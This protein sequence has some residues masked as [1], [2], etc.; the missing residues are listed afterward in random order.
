[1]STKLPLSN[2]EAVS[3]YLLDQENIKTLSACEVKT[4][5]IFQ[6]EYPKSDGVYDARMGTL[7]YAWKCGTCMQSKPE[8]P[9][10][11]GSIELNYPVIHPFYTKYIAKLLKAVCHKCGSIIN[12]NGKKSLDFYAKQNASTKE[13]SHQCSCKNFNPVIEFDKTKLYFKKTV[14]VKKINKTDDARPDTQIMHNFET[15]NILSRITKESYRLMGLD[16]IDPSSLILR[17]LIIPANSIRPELRKIKS[18]RVN[19]N[20]INVNL[21][22][23]VQ[24][25]NSISATDGNPSNVQLEIGVKLSNVITE[26]IK[27]ST[28]TGFEG[29]GGAK[30]NSISGAW[31]SKTGRIRR[32]ILG[33]R[34]NNTARGFITCDPD[35]EIDEIGIPLLVAK[36]NEAYE[37]VTPQNIDRL[38]TYLNNGKKIYPGVLKIIKYTETGSYEV[39]IGENTQIKEGDTVVRN[40]ITG[41][42]VNFNRQPSL[43]PSSVSSMRIKV[44]PDS[45]NFSNTKSFRMNV[46]SCN[47]FGADFDG[48]AMTIICPRSTQSSHEISVLSNPGENFVTYKNAKPKLG[49]VLDS[50]IGIAE[51]TRSKTNYSKFH[52]MQ[53]FSKTK[54]YPIFDKEKYSGRELVSFLLTNNRYHINY[55]GKPQFYDTTTAINCKY[56]PNDI[57]VLIDNGVLKTGVLDNASIGADTRG[58][59]FHLIHNKL[60]SKAAMES[61]FKIQ[62]IA[63]NHIYHYGLTVNIDDLMLRKEKLAEIFRIES[64]LIEESKRITKN[65]HDGNIIAPLG[66][67]VGE[68]FENLQI[69]TLD[70]NGHTSL[71]NKIIMSGINFDNN[72]LYQMIRYG[73]KGKFAH[74]RNISSSVGQILINGER[75]AENFDGRTLAFYK[76][77]DDRPQARGFIPNNYFVGISPAQFYIHS[78]ESRYQLIN[79]ALSTS[80]TGDQ[81]RRAIKS[82]E[83][84]IVNNLR[85]AYYNGRIIQPM[86]GIEGTDPRFIELV[87]VPIAD[88]KY[89]DTEKLKEDYLLTTDLDGKEIKDQKQIYL[90]DY[91]KVEKIAKQIQKKLK[92]LELL[93]DTAYDNK[94]Y[95]PVSIK[96]ILDDVKFTY[97]RQLP[98]SKAD[99]I[100]MY[101]VI[102][103]YIKNLGCVLTNPNFLGKKQ[104]EAIKMSVFMSK[105]N[106][107]SYLNLSWLRKNNIGLIEIRQI[108]ARYN[109]AYKKNLVAY[110]KCVGIIAAQSVSEPL[111]QTVLDSRHFS[112]V[113]GSKKKGIK[114]YTEIISANFKNKDDSPSMNIFIKEPY[115]YDKEI[116]QTVANSIEMMVLGNYVTSYQIFYEEFANPQTE[117]LKDEKKWINQ[118]MSIRGY[119]KPRDLTN[120]CI[121]IAFNKTK[122]FEKNLSIED[123]YLK[124]AT[125]SGY[126]PVY[127]VDNNNI[128]VMRI[129]IKN[130]LNKGE[131]NEKILKKEIDK[132]D[133]LSVRGIEGIVATYVKTIKR[134]NS[135][136]EYYIVT[137]GSNIYDVMENPYVDQRL[138]Q[139]DSIGE[140]YK[141]FGIRA[142]RNK[143]ISELE[144]QVSGVN[145][146]HY[147]MYAEMMTHTGNIFAINRFGNA[148]RGA[149]ILVRT[150]DSSPVKNISDAAFFGMSDKTQ[151]VSQSLMV[152]KNPNIGGLYNKVLLDHDF[153]MEKSKETKQSISDL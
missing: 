142:A 118:F 22:S 120:W 110:G 133:V 89:F 20:D 141:M 75:I 1:M 144:V 94:V 2:I 152:G 126:Y 147:T 93:G 65:L 3:F 14:F 84:I 25:N 134:V 95:V 40:L 9:G 145:Q 128:I 45:Q 138:L 39:E 74:L 87:E 81:N 96:G 26:Y 119:T 57:N 100:E 36:T 19:N 151:G 56:D 47:L 59:L 23:I 31:K 69:N 6:D 90:E 121:R 148:K 122:L 127:T 116:V 27:G 55:K 71:F 28:A 51:L 83:G 33:K 78:E 135:E 99:E 4:P 18:N 98:Q 109:H 85:Q 48:D 79:T 30:K 76:K 136:V 10:H 153:I 62:Q 80:V 11:S 52:A 82:L 88:P 92:D 46:I 32:N 53:V 102:Q 17:T 68:H 66:K 125:I 124:V 54:T 123:I 140:T 29:Y 130:G 43:E 111:T 12:S 72:G 8:C 103:N 139:T 38:K 150:S 97:K 67:T 73:S 149:S 42:V 35:M 63:I 34:S 60:G 104:S 115:K 49:Q 37:V 86:Y 58:G 15:Y 21:Q 13:K 137:D 106:L 131:I 129:Y 44:V 143:I 117:F 107:R 114:R 50:V 70:L 101:H 105:V 112:G 113:G 5:D 16:Y 64:S 77:H 146:R 7:D 24:L 132:L 108:L 41:D 91:A 61:V